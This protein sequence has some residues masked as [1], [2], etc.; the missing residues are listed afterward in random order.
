MNQINRDNERDY[1]RR[2]ID[3][4]LSSAEF[5][6]LEEQLHADP[7]LRARYV[8]Y[9]GFESAIGET[10]SSAR[11]LFVEQPRNVA[12]PRPPR[13]DNK[14]RTIAITAICCLVVLPVLWASV[15]TA[16][17]H[18][19]FPI[20]TDLIPAA[21]ISEVAI[22]DGRVPTGMKVGARCYPGTLKVPAGHLRLD[23]FRGA[24]LH[25]EGP[26]VLRIISADAATLVSGKLAAKINPTTSGFVLNTPSASLVDQ[27]SRF[28]VA[29]DDVGTCDIQILEGKIEVSLLGLDGQMFTT[30]SLA[31]HESVCIH[32]GAQP[33]LKKHVTSRV[34]MPELK[35]GSWLRPLAVSTTYVQAVLDAGPAIYWRFNDAANDIVS[36]EIEDRFSGLLRT[37]SSNSRNISVTDG[38]LVFSPSHGSSQWVEVD[39]PV[40]GLNLDSFTIEFWVNPSHYHRAVLLATLPLIDERLPLHDRQQMDHLNLVETRSRPESGYETGVFRFLHRDPPGRTGGKSLFSHGEWVPGQWHHLACT[41]SASE[42][43]LYVNGRL[44]RQVAGESPIGDASPFRLILGTLFPFSA[45]RVLTGAIDEFAL[46]RRE[47]SPPQ[48]QSHYQLMAV[49][50]SH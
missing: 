3:D 44:A 24:Q 36:N 28:A 4:E 30:C 43:R 13:A 10:V 29:V 25:I 50:Q 45:D 7:E 15:P 21:T 12:S 19:L 8:R 6:M 41:K 46:Y 20:S 31:Q 14:W 33:R 11:P 40:P 39:E 18:A 9:V 17:P 27:G 38:M 16:A 23:F 22:P 2:L 1:F 5:L 47:L 37:S 32:P 34:P 49:P 35:D 26:A 48:I 42:V